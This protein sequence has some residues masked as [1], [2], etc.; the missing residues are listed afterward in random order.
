VIIDWYFDFI[1]PF[2]YL[3]WVRLGELP[4]S[5]ELRPKPVLLGAILKHWGQ[6]GPAEIPPKRRFTY[7]H[8]TWLAA[9]RGLPFTLP[10][11]HP[12]NPLPLLRLAWALG[13]TAGVIER[14]FRFVWV[15]GHIPQQAGPWAALLAELGLAEYEETA[16]AKEQLR[17]ATDAAIARDVFGVPT[18][19]AH[20]QLIWGYDATEL[21]LEYC[22]DPGLFASAPMRHALE[23]PV[24]AARPARLV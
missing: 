9:R 18:A 12:F 24:A 19:I 13:P 23:I 15:E 7:Q 5:V 16:A 14:L 21:L 17:Q 4:S 6:L 22:R 2:A 20:G 10:A 1:S 3:Q 11:G 8:V